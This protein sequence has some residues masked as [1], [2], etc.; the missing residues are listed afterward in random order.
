MQSLS[1]TLLAAQKSEKFTPLY[2]IVFSHGG[3]S[4]EFT[5]RIRSISRTFQSAS[6]KATIVCENAGGEFT[7]LDLKGW[8]AHV[9]RGVVT[10]A[11]EEWADWPP[12]Y[13]VGQEFSS[14]PGRLLC[15]FQLEGIPD[16]LA[17]DQAADIYKGTN[18][19][20]KGAVTTT[21]AINSS[22]VDLKDIT[23]FDKAVTS[24]TIPNLSLLTIG[25]D[26]TRYIIIADATITAGAA[27]I[28]ITPWLAAVA[29]ADAVITI[30]TPGTYTIKE[31]I[32]DLL[33]NALPPFNHCK[34]Y[35]VVWDDPNI[36][37]PDTMEDKLLL[38]Q[39][40]DSF[41]VYPG[42]TR[43]SIL[44]LLLGYTN[45]VWR[46]DADGNIHIFK[47]V[48]SGSV[49]DYEYELGSGNH[50]FFAKTYRQKLVNPNYVVVRS[51][52]E[53][54]KDEDGNPY[55]G[56]AF[57]GYATDG[58][59][60]LIEK[61]IYREMTLTSNQQAEAIA[62]AIINKASMTVAGGSGAVPI[63]LGQELY[64]YIQIIDARQGDALQGNVGYIIEHIRPLERDAR[65]AW[66]M[67]VGFGQRRSEIELKR[68]SG[69]SEQSQSYEDMTAQNSFARNVTADK[70]DV[71]SLTETDLLSLL[72][73]AGY[74]DMVWATPGG[75]GW[76]VQ[77]EV[78]IDARTGMV[79]LR[80]IDLAF[81]N[82]TGGLGGYIYAGN[83]GV[84]AIGAVGGDILLMGDVT[85]YN[86]LDMSSGQ[87]HN[88]LDPS[89]AQ[90]AATQNYVLAVIGWHQANYHGANLH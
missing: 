44:E 32:E 17:D 58:S 47:P 61:R 74:L 29:Y 7:V 14:V 10:S 48:I 2:K 84:L 22:T 1:A 11:G 59:C 33:S 62:Q 31:L 15:E 86:D 71:S 13:V 56:R 45:S 89:A 60:S 70:I 72:I 16:A 80:D 9:S 21:K 88:L 64:D 26:P 25:E 8:E 52:L 50:S 79:I 3:D 82:V 76:E 34:S 23:R 4:H 85:V 81:T 35:D 43:F 19:D 67:V 83:D 69:R 87:I 51:P 24:G 18:V 46:P 73:E 53:T 75:G 20:F 90:D 38:Y 6:Y 63:N 78:E 65:N 39:P 12:L 5:D 41:R 54:L 40:K 57:S 28:S 49:Y 55:Q 77:R 36:A 42:N 37:N 68:S 27:T 66:R 30:T